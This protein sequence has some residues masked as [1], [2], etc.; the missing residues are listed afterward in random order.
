MARYTQVLRNFDIVIKHIPVVLNPVAD[1]QSCL[2]YHIDP[3]MQ[4][5]SAPVEERV[6]WSDP[7][8]VDPKTESYALSESWFT[9]LWD[10]FGSFDAE[11]FAHPTN[12]RMKPF[13]QPTLAWGVFA[14]RTW[15]GTR[16]YFNP[17]W[18]D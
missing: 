11:G 2:G 1:V 16:W 10:K 4:A 17:K 6:H 13:Y 14:L 9:K 12:F 8:V 7:V 18:S 3:I 5:R 15:M